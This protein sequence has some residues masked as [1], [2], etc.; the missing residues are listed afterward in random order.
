MPLLNVPCRPSTNEDAISSSPARLPPSPPP[1]YGAFCA[2]EAYYSGFFPQCTGQGRRGG[3]AGGVSSFQPKG[4]EGG[5]VGNRSLRIRHR[6][7]RQSLSPPLPPSTKATNGC[8][9]RGNLAP[10][11]YNQGE[12]KKKIAALSFPPP[13][14]RLIPADF[15]P[16]V[17]HYHPGPT[18]ND[19]EK[20][21]GYRLRAKN[22]PLC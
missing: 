5:R 20:R 7:R 11:P 22:G 16:I 21:R 4:R 9:P 15:F 8:G 13:C 3:E 10:P 6:R 14:L 17:L 2:S 19:Y 18:E 1:P 12:K